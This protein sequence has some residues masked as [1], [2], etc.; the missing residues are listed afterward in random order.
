MAA[1]LI[2][3]VEDE[4]HIAQILQIV[5]SHKGFN[6]V[7]AMDGE[8]AVDKLKDIRPDA[9]ILDVMMPKMSG[10]E[11][12][13]FIKSNPA[14]RNIP[15]II[16]STLSQARE[17]EKGREFGVAQYISKDHDVMD[18]VKAVHDILKL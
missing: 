7:H 1:K 12:C 11:V 16:Y 14:T 6:I 17:V 10:W 13:S 18:V 9:V 2:L 8:D 4:P 15:I 5:L 3:L